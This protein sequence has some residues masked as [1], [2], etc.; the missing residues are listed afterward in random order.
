MKITFKRIGPQRR[1]LVSSAHDPGDQATTS[2]ITVCG[3]SAAV[4]ALRDKLREAV[5]EVEEWRGDF[6]RGKKNPRLRQVPDYS[7]G[8]WRYF[9]DKGEVLIDTH[10]P[11]PI[12]VSLR[13]YQR[14]LAVLNA[15][16]F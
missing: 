2:P 14:A 5:K 3:K 11:T 10:K 8:R 15:L 12:R 9:R 16:Y 1:S 4:L 7:G 13:T 6:D